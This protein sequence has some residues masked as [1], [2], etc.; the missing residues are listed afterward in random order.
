M[1]LYGI[2]KC[3][4]AFIRKPTEELGVI[5][6]HSTS[7]VAF[8]IWYERHVCIFFHLYEKQ[9]SDEF[10][11]INFNWDRSLEFC[12]SIPWTHSIPSRMWEFAHSLPCRLSTKCWQY[13]F[14]TQLVSCLDRFQCL[15]LANTSANE[16][17]DDDCFEWTF[18][19]ES[20]C[21]QTKSFEIGDVDF[22]TMH[23][24]KL[25]VLSVY[26]QRK[27]WMKT[28]QRW[29]WPALAKAFSTRKKLELVTKF[30]ETIKLLPDYEPINKIILRN[31]PILTRLF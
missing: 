29:R 30:V 2:F 26:T 18:V 13:Q 1:V 27:E 4:S 22:K 9:Q 24:H 5:W 12:H 6:R 16:D 14:Q 8:L 10:G 11:L 7:H 20:N 28:L 31:Y 21:S 25:A 23:L 15:N 3:L 19:C 17:D